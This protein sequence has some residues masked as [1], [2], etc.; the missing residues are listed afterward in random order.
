MKSPRLVR[1][2]LPGDGG[3]RY[4]QNQP[5]TQILTRVREESKEEFI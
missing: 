4:S 1:Q 5:L 2:H 3:S